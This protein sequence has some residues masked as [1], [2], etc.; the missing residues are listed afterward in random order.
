MLDNTLNVQNLWGDEFKIS[1]KKLIKKATLS[2]KS[3]I[4]NIDDSNILKTLKSTKISLDTKLSLI[5]K[6]VDDVLGHY[7]QDIILIKDKEALNQ[8]A[9]QIIK[10]NIFAIDT[11]TN[12]SL[13]TISCK[14]MGVC[15]YTPKMKQAYI[16][17][18]HIDNSTNE[19]L[20]YQLTETDIKD[21]LQ[22][23][24]DNNVK[25][26]YHNGKFDI[27]VFY[28]TCGLLPPIYWDT[29][30]AARML[31][32]NEPTANLK[33]QYIDK[34]NPEQQKYDI[35]DLFN[36][37][38]YAQVDP[39]TF[40]L[41]AAT[42]ARMTFDLYL[43][44]VAAFKNN[45]LDRVYDIYMNTE[46]PI[47]TIIAKMELN[48]INIDLDYSKR[49]SDKY[50]KVSVELD[51][52]ISLEIN[53][54]TDIINKW[55]LTPEANYHE[56]KV[57]KDKKEKKICKSK[58]EQLPEQI[59]IQSPIQLS[60][61][62]YDILKV[63]VVNSEKPR[64][65]G[66]EEIRAIS[67]KTGLV[68]CDLLLKKK[69]VDKLIDTFIDKL[70]TTINQ[71]DNKIHCEFFNVA[72]DTGRFS[73][74][75]PNLQNIPSKRKDIRC[76]FQASHGCKLV[77][78]DF[79]QLE[80]KTFV[81]TSKDTNMLKAYQDGKDLY[82]V[83]ASMVYNKPYE[84][85]LEFYPE[86]TKLNVDGVEIVCGHKTHQNK[87]GKERRNASK[88]ILLGSLYQSGVALIAKQINKTKKEAKAIMDSFYN[89]FPITTQYMQSVKDY[90]AKYGYVENSFGRR[91]RLPNALLPKYSI[92]TT[93]KTKRENFNPFLICNNK[94]DK[95]LIDKYK[96]LLYSE[97]FI[98]SDKYN[99]IIEDAKKDGVSIVN[100]NELIQ[101]SLRQ[102]VNFM[103]QSLGAD[104]VKR[105]MLKID[106]DDILNNLGF[107]MLLQ[108]H[109]E[110][111]GECPEEN[112]QQVADRLEFLMINIPKELGMIVPMSAD[113][114]Q[115]K[116]WYSDEMEASILDTFMTL[117]KNGVSEKEALESIYKEHE[118]LKKENIY[119]YLINKEE[120]II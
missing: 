78:A 63:P 24:I 105:V 106:S 72:T 82:S 56:I 111:I 103:S 18:N 88:K 62:L 27:K 90:V 25:F 89:Q 102:S 11:E 66:A 43:Y 14:L 5:R 83:I 118:E 55:R 98:P 13:D 85:C 49:L 30:V 8:Y 51:E 94:D 38:Q 16:P 76:M 116:N 71:K 77:G 75:N 86:G 46:I 2:T 87:P 3:Y 15:I 69:T 57:S 120:L 70:P 31:D 36:N 42:D 53:K 119:N 68:F 74:A 26:V 20:D 37:I 79:S 59:N 33:Q 115:V 64:S 84:E 96:N 17:I 80:V 39:E 34:I 104:V 28:T 100:N 97:E 67:E 114:Y 110:I 22:Q 21:F 58:N 10:N 65:T 1:P 61:L 117:T 47:I 50:H 54:Y 45:G 91:R 35:E 95:A 73:S 12:N 107:K 23:L 113:S 29:Y 108:V 112:S 7:K 52:K 9:K 6:R 99:K 60:I 19:R 109:D 101:K 48:G 40:S 92:S 44:Q 32:E 81:H 4:Y 93:T 41:Y